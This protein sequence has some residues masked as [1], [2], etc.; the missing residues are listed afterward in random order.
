M[1]DIVVKLSHKTYPL[2]IKRGLISEI[3]N[4]IT[5]IYSGKKIAIITDSNVNSLYGKIVED[6]LL[7]NNFNVKTVVLEPGE[8]SK[9][10]EVLLEV[11]N[12]LLDFGI[13]RGDLIIALGGGVIGDLTGFAASTL[14]RGIPFVQIPT[15]LLAQID[16]SIGGKVAVDLPKGKNLIGSFYHPEA[17]FIDPNVLTTLSKK[18]LHDGMAEVIKYGA[19]KDENLFHKLENFKDDNELLANIDDIIYTCCNIKKAVVEKDEKDTGD[20]MMLNFGHTLGHAIEKY[21]NFEKYTHGEAVAV[22]MYLI[23]KRSEALGITKETSAEQI[24]SLLIKYELPYE[25]T[26]LD[27]AKILEAIGL[28]KKND[29]NSINIIL[30]NKIGDAFIKKIDNTS[31]KDY[32]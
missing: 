29:K 21:F 18:F 13:T 6:S 26:G 23:T 19:I 10:V 2:Y 17:V 5:K 22:G 14:L 4:E 31:M 27:N 1:N 30:L 3:G 11:Y 9:S 16:S 24:K 8:K 15:S 28:D 32:I 12:S 7:Q 20:R 25:V